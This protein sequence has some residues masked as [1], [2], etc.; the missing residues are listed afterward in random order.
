MVKDKKALE[1]LLPGRKGT[2]LAGFVLLFLAIQ[3]AVMAWF[4]NTFL[5][6]LP[7]LLDEQSRDGDYVYLT[8]AESADIF[9]EDSEEMGFS[10]MRVFRFS[11][12]ES[13]RRYAFFSELSS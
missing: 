6:P 5:A 3:L 10:S 8:V 12:P 7:S 13:I 2:R 11:Q 1:K 9:A 4:S